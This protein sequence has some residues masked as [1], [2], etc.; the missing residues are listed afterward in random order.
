MNSLVVHSKF[1]LSSLQN[2]MEECIFLAKQASSE[3]RGPYVGALVLDSRGKIIG[4][5]YKT[6][7]HGTS[8]IVHAERRALEDAT[9]RG[10]R[11]VTIITTLEPCIENHQSQL[12]Q[13]CSDLIISQKIK[14][15]IIGRTD[16]SEHF[17]GRQC[18][19]YLQNRCVVVYEYFSLTRRIRNELMN[20][21]IGYNRGVSYA[22][23]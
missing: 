15:V 3:V 17:A 14:E 19:H 2:Y 6:M 8:L 1:S 10:G 4:R 7:D 20:R 5:G 23:H 12:L 22:R 9:I 16:N 11:G 13:S 18:T 21:Q